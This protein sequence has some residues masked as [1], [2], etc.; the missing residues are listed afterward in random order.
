MATE[1]EFPVWALGI[2]LPTLRKVRTWRILE[3]INREIT[4]RGFDCKRTTLHIEMF[5]DLT[6]TT[7]Y[8]SQRTEIDLSVSFA[9]LSSALVLRVLGLL[10]ENCIEKLGVYKGKKSRQKILEAGRRGSCSRFQYSR[11][12]WTKPH[13]GLTSASGTRRTPTSC[14]LSRV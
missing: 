7:R 12:G 10:L 13:F 3:T 9:L 1:L 14:A 11:Y 5:K 2:Y 8:F 6:F 4:K